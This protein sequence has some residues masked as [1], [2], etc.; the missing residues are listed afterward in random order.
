MKSK[1]FLLFLFA[2]PLSLDSFSQTTISG[3]PQD[4]QDFQW[5]RDANGKPLFTRNYENA[6]GSPDF[7]EEYCP[8]MITSKGKTYQAP[9]VK[10]N[11]L[12]NV[13]IYNENNRELIATIPIEKVQFAGCGD[14]KGAI[15]FQSGFPGIDGQNDSTFYEVLDTGKIKRLNILK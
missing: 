6:E 5:K 11:L 12:Y 15:I 8:A 10:L 3:L 2:L 9:Q 1:F 13:I 14:S 7:S 4:I